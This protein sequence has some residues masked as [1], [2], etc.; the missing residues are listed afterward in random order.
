MAGRHAS[1]P[2]HG[3]RDATRGPDDGLGVETQGAGHLRLQD[4]AQDR[5]G[6]CP[7]NTCFEF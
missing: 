7:A 2:A 5:P 6:A 3:G 4:H 1:P